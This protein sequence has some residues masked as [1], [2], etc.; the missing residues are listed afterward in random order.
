MKDPFTSLHKIKANLPHWAEFEILRNGVLQGCVC[1][2]AGTAAPAG[3]PGV[4][5]AGGRQ[6][7]LLPPHS[8]QGGQR[9]GH[10]PT[11]RYQSAK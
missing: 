2:D 4:G 5:G 6:P 7:H 8:G 11:C 9:D 3:D 1:G 10:Q